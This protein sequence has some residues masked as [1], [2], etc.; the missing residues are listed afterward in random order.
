MAGAVV[1]IVIVHRYN[2]ARRLQTGKRRNS[3]HDAAYIIEVQSKKKASVDCDNDFDEETCHLRKREDS[4]DTDEMSDDEKSDSRSVTSKVSKGSVS[5]P[6]RKDSAKRKRKSS[7]EPR[8]KIYKP[9]SKEEIC[10]EVKTFMFDDDKKPSL[11]S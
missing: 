11:H 2:I 1:V 9:K 8:S 10:L 4:E 7:Q 3:N 6:H 5:S